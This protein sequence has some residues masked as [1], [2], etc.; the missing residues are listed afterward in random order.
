MNRSLAFIPF[1]VLVTVAGCQRGDK[2]QFANVK[3]KVTYNGSP[4]EKGEIA[5]TH[6]GQPPTTMKI[7]DGAF[8][9]QALVGPNKVA[10]TAYKKNPSAARKLSEHA[11]I[12]MR[13]YQE[14]FKKSPQEGG[15]VSE[16]DPTMVNYIPPEWGAHSKET[17]VV[18]AGAANDFEFNIKGKN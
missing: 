11:Q 12:Q 15:P 14:K 2:P 7:V 8:N 13:G 1:L 6:E 3:G 16:Y 5:F 10:V 4:I 17:R 18:E 9:G